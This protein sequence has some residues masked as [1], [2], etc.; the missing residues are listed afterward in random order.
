VSFNHSRQYRCTIIRGRSKGDMDALLLVYARIVSSVCPCSKE[1]FPEKFNKELI[2]VLPMA[3]KKTL[4]NHRT[5]IAGK[6]FGMYVGSEGYVISS[7]RNEKLLRDNDQPAF[8]KDWCF[9]LQY[10]NGMEKIETIK[11]RVRLGINIR[12]CCFILKALKRAHAQDP[13]IGLSVDEV[14]YYILNSLDVLKGAAEPNEV[15]AQIVNDRKKGIL[16]RVSGNNPAYATQHIREVISY[17]ELANLVSIKNGEVWLNE[18]EQHSVRQFLEA[19]AGKPLFKVDDYNFDDANERATFLS[20]WSKFSGALAFKDS[21]IFETS[22]S[23]LIRDEAAGISHLTADVQLLG[24]EGERVVYNFEKNRVG[25]FNQRL[26]SRVKMLGN[27]RGLGYDVHSVRCEG[28]N[29]DH[30]IY[31][32]V[33][34]TKRLSLPSAESGWLEDTLTLTKN[35]W[36]A[37]EQHKEDY[38]IYRVYF[39]EKGVFLRIIQNPFGQS[40]SQRRDVQVEA[41]HYR[42]DFRCVIKDLK[43]I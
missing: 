30:A 28:R 18:N 1:Q 20:S 15:V 8:F 29:S 32:E 24:D 35:E 6:L 36:L 31:I 25:S 42:M 21:G 37:A 16:R 33:K 41:T 39:T 43:K 23:A 4:D 34:S 10:P 17:L 40:E 26:T 14:G 3:T 11:E 13:G 9:K 27:V 12:P 38:F 22:A 2:R 7:E 5:E 19:D